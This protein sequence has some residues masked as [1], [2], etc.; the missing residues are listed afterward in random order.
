MEELIRRNDISCR[1]NHYD[2]RCKIVRPSLTENQSVN[3]HGS[4]DYLDNLYYSTFVYF[5]Y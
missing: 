2:Y 5:S 1:G 4:M 3:K